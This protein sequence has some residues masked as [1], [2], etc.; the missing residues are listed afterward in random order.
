MQVLA[1][2]SFA[3]II[4][5][6]R[7]AHLYRTDVPPRVVAESLVRSI[8]LAAVFGA[9]VPLSFL[10]MGSGAYLCWLAAPIVLAV[11]RRIQGRAPSG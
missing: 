2:A 6:I 9:S 8:C 4:R 10:P 7:R 3:L 11:A 1:S 5:E